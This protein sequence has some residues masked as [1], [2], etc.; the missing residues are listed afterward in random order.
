MSAHKNMLI[1]ATLAAP[2]LPEA[3][4]MSTIPNGRYDKVLSL[5]A[6]L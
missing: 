6:L 3:Y 2:S 1:E 4:N 5:W